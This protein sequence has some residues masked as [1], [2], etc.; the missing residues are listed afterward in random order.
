MKEFKSNFEFKDDRSYVHSSTLIEEMCRLVYGNFYAEEKWKMPMVD[1]KFH[2][3]IL[4]NGKFLIFED[5]SRFYENISVS[6]DFRFYDGKHNITAVFIEDKGGNVVRRIKTNYS[7][8]DI[9]IE[10]NFSGTCKIACPN[11]A[12]FTENIIEANK[13]IHLLA[14]KD[15]GTDLKI[16]NLYMKRFPVY[17][18]IENYDYILLKIENIGVRPRDDSLATLNSLYFPQLQ[19]ERFEMAYIVEGL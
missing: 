18:S 12:A 13:R 9:I 14:L 10:R 8:E 6:A 17:R 2:K 3:P 19:L 7:V 11:R 16:I 1:A 4:F 5:S 15:K